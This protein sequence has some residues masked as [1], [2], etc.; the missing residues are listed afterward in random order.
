MFGRK[1]V[2]NYSNILLLLDQCG[3]HSHKRFQLNV[4]RATVGGFTSQKTVI[5]KHVQVLC[6]P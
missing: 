2:L 6:L 4:L 1:N 3:T 5:L